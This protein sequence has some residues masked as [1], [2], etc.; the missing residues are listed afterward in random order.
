MARGSLG[1]GSQMWDESWTQFPGVSVVSYKET[2]PF[3]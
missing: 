3:I 2:L 1:L